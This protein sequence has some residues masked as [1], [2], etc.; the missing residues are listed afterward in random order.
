MSKP[1]ATIQKNKREAIHVLIDEFNGRQIFNV[2]VF[3]EAED[4]S[5]RPGKAGIAFSITKLPEFAEAVQKALTEA[6]R[7]GLVP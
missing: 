3:Y 5:V 7:Q 6:Q 2:R 1:V 4:G